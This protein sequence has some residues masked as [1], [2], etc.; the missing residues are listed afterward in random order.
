MAKRRYWRVQQQY[1]NEHQQITMLATANLSTDVLA[2]K[3]LVGDNQA[4]IELWESDQLGDASLA[5]GSDKFKFHR[6]VTAFDAGLG[7]PPF[8]A[9]LW[10]HQL[11]E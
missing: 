9:L 2:L 1:Q 8:L 4:N 5:D 3:A 10:E 7:V 11:S 6:K